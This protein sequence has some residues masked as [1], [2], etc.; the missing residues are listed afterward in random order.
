[1]KKTKQSLQD[2]YEL[3]KTKV[4]YYVIGKDGNVKRDTMGHPVRRINSYLTAD[5][6]K[7]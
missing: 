7:K 6:K 3:S 5:I 2:K 4:G 1:M